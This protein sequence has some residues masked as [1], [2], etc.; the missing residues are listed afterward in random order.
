MLNTN[1]QEIHSGE[2]RFGQI[3]DSVQNMPV[4]ELNM[5]IERKANELFNSS[6]PTTRA[7]AM[8]KL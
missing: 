5:C 2:G 7:P 1:F 3:P 6:V 8:F 4:A